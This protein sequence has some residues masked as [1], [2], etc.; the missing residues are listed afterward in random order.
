MCSEHQPHRCR[1]VRTCQK[2]RAWTAQAGQTSAIPC[3]SN[4]AV[5]QTTKRAHATTAP[6]ASRSKRSMSSV[7]SWPHVSCL[8]LAHHMPSV[9]FVLEVMH[10][11]TTTFNNIP[12]RTGVPFSVAQLPSF[13]QNTSFRLPFTFSSSLRLIFE[14]APGN[15]PNCCR[16]YDG[17]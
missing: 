14:L 10:A 9:D 15:E 11:P 4:A 3:V 6:R 7:R 17:A 5:A 8:S 16:S 1:R 13:S 12:C 2:V